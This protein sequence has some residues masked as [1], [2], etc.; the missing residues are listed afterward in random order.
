M[1]L[2]TISQGY[3]SAAQR[4]LWLERLTTAFTGRPSANDSLLAQSVSDD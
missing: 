1:F 2:E 4:D 3:A